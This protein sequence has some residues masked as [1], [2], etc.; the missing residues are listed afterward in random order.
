M[1]VYIYICIYIFIYLFIY[2]Y[3]PSVARSQRSWSDQATRP[4]APWGTFN[5]YIDR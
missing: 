2:I 3:V 1:Y 4:R 5:I